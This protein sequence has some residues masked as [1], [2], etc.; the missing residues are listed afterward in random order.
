MSE[1]QVDDVDAERRTVG[2]REVD[3]A[4]DITRVACARLVQHFQDDELHFWR[5]AVIGVIVR[6]RAGAADGPG[7]MRTVAVIVE[8]RRARDEILPVDD[9]GLAGVG[10]AEIGMRVDAAIDNGD[11]DSGSIEARIP[12]IRRV[13]GAG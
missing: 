9:A 3:C 5:E 1:R 2:N 11:A 12:C 7:D 6:K 4:N 10:A 8:L 13:D